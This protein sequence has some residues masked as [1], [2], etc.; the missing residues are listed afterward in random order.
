M[1][2]HLSE[3]KCSIM[4]SGRNMKGKTK[5]INVYISIH[6]KYYHTPLHKQNDV[7]HVS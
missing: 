3:T 4:G 7:G 1:S 5:I 2:F 6:N